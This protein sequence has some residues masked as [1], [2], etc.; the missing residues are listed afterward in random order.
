MLMSPEPPFIEIALRYAEIRPPARL[1]TAPPWVRY[2]AGP[3][4]VALLWIVPALATA[5]MPPLTNTPLLKPDIVPPA[6]LLTL[7][8][9]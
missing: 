2:T 9:A 6:A 4:A 7:P 8:P 1:V 3:P 5:P